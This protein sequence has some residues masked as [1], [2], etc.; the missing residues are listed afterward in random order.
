LSDP[1]EQLRFDSSAVRSLI[2]I[3]REEDL[4]RLERERRE[5][6]V[7][8]IKTRYLNTDI[9]KVVDSLKKSVLKE[10]VIE[11]SKGPVKRDPVCVY[12]RP[13]DDEITCLAYAHTDEVINEFRRKVAVIDLGYTL[14]TRMNLETVF[15]VLRPVLYCHCGHGT[16]EALLG[17]DYEKIVDSTNVHI[18]RGC[19]A[20]TMA[21]HSYDIAKLAIDRGCIGFHGYKGPF[22]VM[23]DYT[24]ARLKLRILRSKKKLTPND[25]LSAES[26]ATETVKQALIHDRDNTFAIGDMEARIASLGDISKEEYYKL[27]AQEAH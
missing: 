25:F 2:P 12:T 26:Y 27:V 24:V 17:Q 9:S 23:S 8:K 15:G 18:L 20:S 6:Y 14:A 22:K 1:F 13:M 19:F 16:N 4:D 21:C 7:N 5:R 3:R 11:T 10:A